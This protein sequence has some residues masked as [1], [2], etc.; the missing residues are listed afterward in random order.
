MPRFKFR[1]EKILSFRGHQ[2]KQKQRELA[3][4][5]KLEQE[6]NAKIT[7]ILN[8]RS[9]TQQREQEHLTG[10]I[11]PARLTEYSRYYLK[12]RQ[13]EI[14]GR[15]MLQQI[16]VEVDKR[17]QA[18]VESTRQK[19]IYEKLRERHLRQFTEEYNRALQKENDEIGQQIFLRNH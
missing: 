9:A 11:L 16:G 3:V 17:R 18:L 14:I 12:L 10:N 5:R 7:G 4:V 2:E 19:K 13:M 15:E 6:E 8:D 1:F